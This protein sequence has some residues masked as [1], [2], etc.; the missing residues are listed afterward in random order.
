MFNHPLKKI[1]MF[2]SQT[3]Q[4]H[5]HNKMQLRSGKVINKTASK[6]STDKPRLSK[7][8]FVIIAKQ[9]LDE[10][11][12][13]ERRLCNIYCDGDNSTMIK[14]AKIKEKKIETL[15]NIF[16]FINEHNYIIEESIHE[17]KTKEF[18]QTISKKGIEFMKDI[19]PALSHQLC[20]VANMINYKID[21][22]VKKELMHEIQVFQQFYERVCIA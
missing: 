16:R 22:V 14:N 12:T 10:F 2:A 17:P 6:P 5:S 18:A 7:R 21:K 11:N 19:D 1:E 15:A 3:I 9:K 20:Y 8:D 13:I 4:L